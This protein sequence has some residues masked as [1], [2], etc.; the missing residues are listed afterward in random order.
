[1]KYNNFDIHSL[2]LGALRDSMGIVSQNAEL[3]DRSVFDNIAYGLPEGSVVSQ[4]MVE[5]ACKSAHAHEFIKALPGGYNARLGRRGDM[6]S[7]GQRQRVALARCLI[8]KPKLLMLD[9]ATSALDTNSE[10]EVQQAVEDAQIGRTTI[11]V[12]HRLTSVRSADTIFVVQN[13]MVVEQGT[14]NGLLSKNGKYADLMRSQL[15]KV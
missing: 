5:D 13:G 14:H 10:R 7:G 12:A 8:R 9:E 4:E 1:M 15:D 11:I 3:F 6:L 2:H